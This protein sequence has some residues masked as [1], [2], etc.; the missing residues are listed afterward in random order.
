MPAHNAPAPL[1]DN[2]A[3]S[4]RDLSP[5]CTVLGAVRKRISHAAGAVAAA[6]SL[7]AALTVGS[8]GL[9]LA[10]PPDITAPVIS[11]QAPTDLTSTTATIHWSTNALSDSQLEFRIQGAVAWS[12][13]ALKA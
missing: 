8:P 10:A 11:Y 13:T 3:F 4:A 6:M 2:A 12:S 1:R 5:M 7:A 9:A